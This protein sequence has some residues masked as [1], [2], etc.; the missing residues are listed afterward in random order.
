[1]LGTKVAS[2]SR[3]AQVARGHSR[4]LNKEQHD[5]QS[6]VSSRTQ[7]ERKSSDERPDFARI[8]HRLP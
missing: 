7:W 5:L 4:G 2:G 8:S 3:R 1:M 6:H